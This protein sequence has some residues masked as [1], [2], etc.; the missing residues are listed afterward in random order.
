MNQPI[1]KATMDA[2]R[3]EYQHPHTTNTQ[4]LKESAQQFEAL[5]LKQ[6][7]QAMDKT[8]MRDENPE[9]LFSGGKHEATFRDM[10]YDEVS[11]S[12]TTPKN[13]PHIPHPPDMMNTTPST[14]LFN[15]APSTRQNQRELG[16][17]RSIFEQGLM[18]N[19]DLLDPNTA[20]TQF[21]TP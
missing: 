5:L 13:H 9:G 4:K 3:A 19:P 2:I 17:A 12:Y 16:L 21:Q 10:F 7:F 15:T 11:K 8:T 18:A 14:S 1:L 6:L 20:L